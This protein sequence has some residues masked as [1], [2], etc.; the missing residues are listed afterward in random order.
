MHYNELRYMELIKSRF[1][2]LDL[3][4]IEFNKTDGS[5]S[6]IAIV[7]NEVVFKFAKYDWSTVYLRNEAEVTGLIRNFIALPLP[8][9]VLVDQNTIKREYIKG[10]PLYRNALLKSDHHTQ[11]T[12]AMQMGAFLEQLHSIPVKKAKNARIEESRMNLAREDWL[13]ELEALERK[14]S[15]YCTNYVKEYLKQIIRPIISDEDFFAFQP[16]LIHGDLTPAHI[17]IDLESRKING[18]IGF[19]NAGFGDPAY[20]IGML[21]DHLGE[22]FIRRLSRYYQISPACMERARFYA[23]ISSFMWYGDVCDMITTRDFSS[24]RISVKDRDI[25]PIGS[26]SNANIAKLSKK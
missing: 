13:T 11:D 25:S 22:S 26:S 17:L 21:L 7:N 1:P 24:F 9:V 20:D 18:I 15:P 8:E 6:D 10:S 5:Y 12:V 2:Q 3:S 14:I 23:Y 16:V 4:K 19:T